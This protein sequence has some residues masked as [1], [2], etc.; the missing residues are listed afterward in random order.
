MISQPTLTR[1]YT[2]APSRYCT[3][4]SSGINSSVSCCFQLSAHKK[5]TESLALYYRHPQIFSHIAPLQSKAPLPFCPNSTTLSPLFIQAPYRILPQPPAHL[6]ASFVSPLSV[7]WR[8]GD[9]GDDGR[10][11]DWGDND[12]K[13]R[14]YS[15]KLQMI[16]CPSAPPK[17][18]HQSESA[19][20]PPH[21]LSSSSC[22]TSLPSD[23]C[24]F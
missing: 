8:L 20:L 10:G 17:P 14:K 1:A 24:V 4:W 11:D 18:P 12:I 7:I 2:L 16:Q 19:L 22:F 13:W 9:S 23:L 21:L 5:T 6:P 15:I 3:Q